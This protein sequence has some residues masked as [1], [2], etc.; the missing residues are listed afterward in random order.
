MTAAV[1][2]SRQDFLNEKEARFLSSLWIWEATKLISE[3]TPPAT[4]TVT[5]EAPSFE[6]SPEQDMVPSGAS[7]LTP[8]TQ[9]DIS[10]ENR[11]LHGAQRRKS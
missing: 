1:P 9:L 2:D 11:M 7:P 10:G 6:W 4:Y 3:C 5:R 8:L